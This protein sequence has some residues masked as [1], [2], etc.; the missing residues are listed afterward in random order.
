M[1]DETQRPA[2]GETAQGQQQAQQQIQFNVDTSAMS[3]TGTASPA[4][5]RS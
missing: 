2:G 5:P 3:S 1:T 4:R